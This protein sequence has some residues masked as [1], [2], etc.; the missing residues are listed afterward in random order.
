[1]PATLTELP[2]PCTLWVPTA[3][4]RVV[5]WCVG[6]SAPCLPALPARARLDPL[7]G[8]LW[9]LAWLKTD[10]ATAA[11]L[12]A[13]LPPSAT[14]SVTLCLYSTR[15]MCCLVSSC[16]SSSLPLAPAHTTPALPSRN[17]SQT[18]AACA[19]MQY[20]IVRRQRLPSPLSRCGLAAAASEGSTGVSQSPS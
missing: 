1:M 13:S 3:P 4:Q 20:S 19:R 6:C 7:A 10:Q 12:H 8:V 5:C 2:S 9:P 16:V 11:A 15:R 14:G 17:V 18:H